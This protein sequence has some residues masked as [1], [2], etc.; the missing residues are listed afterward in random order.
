[1]GGAKKDR[2][3]LAGK[4]A[5]IMLCG[6]QGS[7]KTTHCAKLAKYLKKKGE[8]KNPLIGCLRFQRPAAVEQL[9]TLGQQIGV[10]VFSIPG[11]KDPV[12]VAKEALEASQSREVMMS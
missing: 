3:Y 10:P 8:A 7:G 2:L 5:V 4:P 12:R 1:M 11:E 6:L 9:K